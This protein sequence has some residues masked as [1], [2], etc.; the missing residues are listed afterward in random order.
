VLRK[1]DPEV[2]QRLAGTERPRRRTYYPWP[3]WTDGAVWRAKKGEDFTCDTHHF[4]TALHQRARLIGMTVETGT[5][6]K[7]VV[8]FVFRKR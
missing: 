5:P 1:A 2:A 3:Q 7:D 6:E 4:Q 8:E